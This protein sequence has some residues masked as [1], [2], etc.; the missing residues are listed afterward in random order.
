MSSAEQIREWIIKAE[1]MTA[2][3]AEEWIGRW[4]VETVASSGV[5]DL[6]AWLVAQDVLSDFHG[7]AFLAGVAGPYL[8]GPYRVYEKIAAG[9]LGTIFRAVHVEFQQPVSLKVFPSELSESPEKFAR[10]GR[11]ARV[12]VEVDHPNLVRTFHIG[13]EAGVT[14]M[15]IEDLHGETLAERLARE[16]KLPFPAACAIVRQAAVGLDYLH[17]L[18]I[19]HRDVQPGNLWITPSGAVKIMEF[20][21]ARDALEQLDALA[22]GEQPTMM[23]V[24]V[25]TFDYMAPEQA[26]NAHE[27]D[28]RS[29][30]YSLGCTLFHCLTGQVPFPD[31]NPIRQMMRHN[32]EAPKPV[33]DLAP[34]T[35]AALA[36]TVAACLAK[37]PGDRYKLAK[38]VAWAI[39][40]FVAPADLSPSDET[41]AINEDFLQWSRSAEGPSAKISVAVSS[42]EG[43]EFMHWLEDRY[44]SGGK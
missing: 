11:E 19:V 28:A 38:D 26:Q 22:S 37:K 1:L 31:K 27:A 21:A 9:R 33:T 17:S 12:A 15:A 29:D 43:A 35:P 20:G 16:K 14:Y 25:G 18:G 32:N 4:R 41:A 2:D 8:V 13:E 5:D 39:E 34:D 36:E 24:I 40:Q 44:G 30:I 42:P 3:A 7:E 6:V 23:D 10:L